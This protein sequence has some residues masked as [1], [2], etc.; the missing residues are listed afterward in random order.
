[1]CN[2]KFAILVCFET[3]WDW[4]IYVGLTLGFNIQYN[5][6]RD[7]ETDNDGLNDVENHFTV[8]V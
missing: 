2:V 1:M 4:G 3:L 7:K 5:D 6:G 8:S